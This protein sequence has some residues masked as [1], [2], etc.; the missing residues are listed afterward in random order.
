MY[1]IEGY[2]TSTE[3]FLLLYKTEEICLLT[4]HAK[5]EQLPLSWNVLRAPFL[6]SLRTMLLDVSVRHNSILMFG[7]Q[8]QCKSVH[9][10][11]HR[12]RN[13]P[14]SWVVINVIASAEQGSE[15]CKILQILS[16]AVS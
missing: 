9:R 1:E 4:K 12:G 3:V 2:G 6:Q 5:K 8:F 13:P 11:L 14:C 10:T 15:L 16:K 7:G